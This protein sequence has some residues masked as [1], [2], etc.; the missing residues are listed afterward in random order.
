MR[1][2]NLSEGER[3]C[4]RKAT[5]FLQTEGLPRSYAYCKIHLKSA[6][7]HAITVRAKTKIDEDVDNNTRCQA[8]NRNELEVLKT[9]K[10]RG[11]R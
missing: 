1:N 5:S 3:Q 8:I 11:T 9:R 2:L 10:K 4:P 7:S 6:L